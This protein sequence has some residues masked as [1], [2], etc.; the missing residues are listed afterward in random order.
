MS[1]LVCDGF[2]YCIILPL[3]LLC[4]TVKQEEEEEEEEEEEDYSSSCF[5][6]C[7]SKARGRV[8]QHPNPS[9]TRND[10]L[11]QCHHSNK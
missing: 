6:V 5:T 8:I 10:M 2:G 3:A 7:D 11:P 9:Q 1:F 4:V